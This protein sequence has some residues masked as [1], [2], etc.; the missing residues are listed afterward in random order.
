MPWPW[1]ASPCLLGLLAAS[2]AIAGLAW[3]ASRA[4]YDTDL[5]PPDREER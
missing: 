4:P 2:L 1:W 5:W 3:A